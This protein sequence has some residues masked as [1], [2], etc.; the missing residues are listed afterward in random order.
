MALTKK[1]Q[2]FINEYL[3]SFN[4]TQAAIA[5]GSPKKSAYS[6]GW[7]LLRNV[8]VSEVIE[9]RLQ[10][11]A[12]SA[13]E[14]LMRLGQQ[15]RAEYSL[16][17]DCNGTVNLVKLLNDGKSHL[18]KSVKETKYGQ[19]I[20]FYDSQSALNILAKHHGLL[21]DRIKQETVNLEIDLNDLD[22]EQIRR[23]ANGESLTDVLGD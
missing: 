23:L 6:V 22:N 12:M 5:S 4:A 7:A 15:A 16:Y 18:I 8:E 14:V 19:Q 1:R 13:N 3:K 17:I 10:E 20:E 21:T 9:K 11:N 2:I